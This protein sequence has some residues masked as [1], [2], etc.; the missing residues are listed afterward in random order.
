MPWWHPA[1]LRRRVRDV[2]GPWAITRLESTVSRRSWAQTQ[3]LGRTLGRFGYRVHRRYR[4]LTRANLRLAFGDELPPERLEQV[5][6]Q[7]L[8]HMV[9]LFLEALRMTHMTPQELAEVAQIEGREHFEAAL[10]AGKGALLFSGHFGNWEIGAVRLIYE[11]FPVIPLSR[12]SSSPR[13]AKRITA[14]REKL[15]FPV[16]PI[17]EGVRGI[18]RALKSNCLVPIMPDR[19]ARSEGV[20]VPFFGQPTHVWPTPAVIALRTGSPILPAHAIRQPDGRFL[21]RID[22]PV[23]L[24]ATGDRDFDIWRTTAR[25]MATLEELIRAHPEQFTWPYELWRPGQTPPSPYPFE[26][27]GPD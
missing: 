11:G 12:A 18:L 15:D 9:M 27:A 5:T 23:E 13:V 19:F 6:S 25:T 16:I 21:V 2:F 14:I 17:S 26:R 24:S 1:D 22:P 7:C 4:S 3:A 8:Q 10:A 20:T